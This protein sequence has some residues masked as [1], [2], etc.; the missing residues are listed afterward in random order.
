MPGHI[1]GQPNIFLG[2]AAN[3]GGM[4]VFERSLAPAGFGPGGHLT[5][6]SLPPRAGAA[7]VSQCAAREDGSAPGALYMA[8]VGLARFVAL[9]HLLIRWPPD[10]LTY[11][12]PLF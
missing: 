11:S 10:S 1:L 3:V 4:P 2:Q 12:V 8:W 9:H 7:A 6:G 5:A